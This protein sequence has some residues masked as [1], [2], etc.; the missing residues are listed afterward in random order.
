MIFLFAYSL[1][2]DN[3]IGNFLLSGAAIAQWIH[4]RLPSFCPRFESK[5]HNLCFSVYSLLYYSCHCNKQRTKINKKRPGLSD[6]LTSYSAAVKVVWSIAGARLTGWSDLAMENRL[7]GTLKLCDTFERWKLVDPIDGISFFG[8]PEAE[9][10]FDP[11]SLP[12]PLPDI[13]LAPFVVVVVDFPVRSVV[14]T[15]WLDGGGGAENYNIYTV[16]PP[17][18][19]RKQILE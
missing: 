12:L 18:I 17:P 19:C 14:D 7:S 1:Y 6:I 10:Q 4:L 11:V 2:G 3:E 9:L 8:L 13:L 16:L 5:A 15:A